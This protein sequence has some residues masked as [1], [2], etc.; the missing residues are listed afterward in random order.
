MKLP[1]QSSICYWLLD[2]L[3]DLGTRNSHDA[4]A[5]SKTD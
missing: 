5:S 2:I 1:T 3:S 4:G